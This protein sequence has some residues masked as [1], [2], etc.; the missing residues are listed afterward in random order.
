MDK[1]GTGWDAAAFAGGIAGIVGAYGLGLLG[2][3]EK[4]PE[5]KEDKAWRVAQKLSDLIHIIDEVPVM[6][7][8]LV[9]T[10]GQDA[11]SPFNAEVNA[12]LAK[13]AVLRKRALLVLTKLYPLVKDRYDKSVSDIEHNVVSYEGGVAEI[14][15][16]PTLT[17]DEEQARRDKR[18]V[19]Q[20]L[21]FNTPF[22][23]A[24]IIAMA[25]VPEDR[26]KTVLGALIID[27]RVEKIGDDAYRP[28][29]KVEPKQEPPPA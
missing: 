2:S 13:L 6:A 19:L 3:R 21:P 24:E 23:L 27:G 7:S 4:E 16:M 17:A 29:P 9:G 25:G 12:R 15:A 5:H 26:V 8:E 18:L 10:D 20:S 14:L 22:A 11:C 1:V 28:K